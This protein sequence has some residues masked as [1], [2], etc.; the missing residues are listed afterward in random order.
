MAAGVPV[1]ATAVD[2]TPEVVEDGRTGLLVPPGRPAEAAQALLRMVRDD[3]LRERCVEEA[4]RRLGR[5]FD[6][7]A[8]VRDLDR[9]YSS[10]L[11]S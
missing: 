4:R 3:G 5:S 9:L 1:V 8:M 7:R 6:I 10:L 2:G 11:Q